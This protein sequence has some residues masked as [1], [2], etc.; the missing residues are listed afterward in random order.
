MT[1]IAE[2]VQD[3]AGEDPRRWV[4][5]SSTVGYRRLELALLREILVELRELKAAV[6]RLVATIEAG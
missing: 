1:D 4:K 3:V 6:A 2:I 5:L